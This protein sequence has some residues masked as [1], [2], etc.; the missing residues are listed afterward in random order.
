[1]QVIGAGFGRTGTLSLKRA[2]E[3][4]GLGPTYHMQEIMRRPAH[5][6][7]WL[8]VARTGT[9]DWGALFA[10]FGSGVDYP[11]CCVWEE[12][13]A[14]YPDAKV[15]LTVRDPES[16]WD[17]TYSTIYGFRTAFPRWFQRA[18]PMAGRFVDMVERLV[19]QGLFDGRFA[20]RDHAIDIFTRHIDHVRTTCPPER[21]LVFDVADGW[22][23]LCEFLALPTPDRPFPH[24]ND[25]A[26]TRRVVTS[27]RWGT[28]AAP[29]V[30]ATALA[31]LV[32]SRTRR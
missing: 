18:V 2:L 13:A 25:A 26:M 28:R 8:D 10:R 7:R 22:D 29:A 14:Y 24:L 21:L 1:M 3:E 30:G 17:S 5:V 6:R 4:L 23:P 15:V 19:W 20:D 12:L 11:V 16:W 31:A 32:M 9:A 27:V